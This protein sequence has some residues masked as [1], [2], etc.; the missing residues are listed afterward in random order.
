MDRVSRDTISLSAKALL[1]LFIS[2]PV[3]SS[4]AKMCVAVVRT[5][6][7]GSYC[8]ACCSSIMCWV[9]FWYVSVQGIIL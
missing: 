6:S 5:L 2:H 4:I 8:E 9:S 7:A 1:Y 3:G